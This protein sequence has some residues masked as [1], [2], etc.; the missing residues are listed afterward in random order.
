MLVGSWD[1]SHCG[2]FVVSAFLAAVLVGWLVWSGRTFSAL[3]IVALALLM[4]AVLFPL[5]PSLSD[6]AYRYLWDGWAQ[7]E[8]RN[9]YLGTPAGQPGFQQA[10]P[11]LYA[12]MNSRD[13][14]SVYPPLS[15]MIFRAPG[16]LLAG[17]EGVR[18]AFYLLK[19]LFGLPEI[20]AVAVLLRTVPSRALVPLYA[21]NPLPAVEVWGQGHTEGAALFLLVLGIALVQGRRPALAAA[22]WTAAAWI[23]LWPALLLPLLARR[24][25]F[26]QFAAAA[27]V[28]LGLTALLWAPYTTREALSGFASSLRLYLES[29]EFNA[30]IYLAIKEAFYA[31]PGL[32]DT[33][34]GGW[35]AGNVLRAGFLVVLGVVMARDRLAD[36]PLPRAAF[37]L[38]AAAILCSAVVHPW[39]LLLSL[40]VVPY[41]TRTPWHWIW[42][43][44]VCP[45]SYLIYAQPAWQGPLATG[46]WGS[47]ALVFLIGYRHELADGLLRWRACG[48][49]RFLQKA[50]Q[51]A[52]LSP[53][54]A[55]VLDVGA[56]EG[57]V[58]LRMIRIWKADVHLVDV[59]SM[60]RTGLAC[61][62]YDDGQPLPFPDR[63]FDLATSVYTL[64]H[65]RDGAAV[66]GEL[67][68]VSRGPAVVLESVYRSEAGRRILTGLD[69]LVN[70]FRPGLGMRGQQGGLQ[71]RTSAQWRAVFEGWGAA[72][73]YQRERFR[74]PHRSAVFVL[75]RIPEGVGHSMSRQGRLARQ[76][77]G[78]WKRK[79]AAV[80]DSGEQWGHKPPA[81]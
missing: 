48:K 29:F 56:G 72:V 11:E 62:V 23:K 22:A 31:I 76:H 37:A 67:L 35:A 36:W 18:P 17:G 59:R 39:Y 78:E 46:I 8:G 16:K 74:F 54:G 79:D 13:L 3:E 38:L 65:C 9:P 71:F 14:H 27:A 7:T 28:S 81:E 45:L 58:G 53:E 41:L 33:G 10:Q 80:P 70:R 51:R 20:L 12:R 73:L 52:G 1:R 43:T 60:N 57:Y 61:T 5:P 30:G 49:V 15:Q 6:D 21:W 66:A 68:R 2:L 77:H 69:R 47:W 63:S 50:L 24:F 64:H 44:A 75:E 34:M 25:R 40:A 55:S 26:G 42:L 4:R 32:R 19:L